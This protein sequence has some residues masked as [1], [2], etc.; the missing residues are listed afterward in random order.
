MLFLST[1][2][3]IS[4]EHLLQVSKLPEIMGSLLLTLMVTIQDGL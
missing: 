2:Q 4:I 3:A 1:N